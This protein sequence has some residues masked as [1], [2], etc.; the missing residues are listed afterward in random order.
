[1]FAFYVFYLRIDF[2]RLGSQDTTLRLT[3]TDWF[4]FAGASLG[5]VLRCQTARLKGRCH[6]RVTYLGVWRFR[7]RFVYEHGK[8][9]VVFVCE[10]NW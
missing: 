10:W 7:D 6:E 8:Y 1:M 9:C 4:R 3:C 5:W 2:C